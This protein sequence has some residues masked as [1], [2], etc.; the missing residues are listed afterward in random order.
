MPDDLDDKPASSP[1][2]VLEGGDSPLANETPPEASPPREETTP[3][4][5]ADAEAAPKEGDRP[6]DEQGRF[7]PDAKAKAP[8]DPVQDAMDRLARPADKKAPQK[9]QAPAAKAEPPKAD[10][11]AKPG[12]REPSP[13][14]DLTP[15]EI[16]ALKP[17]TRERIETITRE[18]AEFR[19]KLADLESKPADPVVGEFSSIIKEHDLQGDLGF[20]P[21]EHLAGIVR[22]QAALNRAAIATQQGRRPAAGDLQVIAQVHEQ[23][24]GYAKAYGLAPPATSTAI[25]PVKGPLPQ[26]LA[27]MV[28]IYGVPE[29]EARLLAAIRASKAPASA[30]TTP[31][32]A[33]TQ[34]PAGQPAAEGVDMDQIYTGRLV[35][36]LVQDGVHK[37][38]LKAHMIALGDHQAR[39]V[40]RRF[41][42]VPQE[43]VGEVF[44][45]LPAAERYEITLAAHRAFR[46]ARPNPT[47]PA[48]PPPTRSGIT[49]GQ[50]PRRSGNASSGDFVQ[51]AIAR[52]SRPEE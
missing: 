25:E 36:A 43:R 31:P 24:N 1:G 19:R 21:P 14:K 22:V 47:P 13:Q 5:S 45:A 23:V 35:S 26:D 49:A 34:Q 32:P 29:H 41:P 17:K 8:P 39:E 33:A 4:P 48:A 30:P 38:H 20:V 7:A 42:T 15:E 51:D 2:N 27:D 40:L 37:D 10:E 52:L 12:Q 46:A 3:A 28:E 9:P 50:A 18:N 44:N 6:R 16:A 11:P